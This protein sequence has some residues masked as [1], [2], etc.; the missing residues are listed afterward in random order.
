MAYAFERI[1][2]QAADRILRLDINQQGTIHQTPA[3]LAFLAD[4]QQG[5]LV[6]ATLKDGETPLGS[7]TGLI[8]R[9]FGLRILGSPFPGWSTDYMGFALSAA[10]DRSRAVNA[11]IEFAFQDLGC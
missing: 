4:S 3:W 5:E 8:V 9:K 6:F 2:V 7:F 11:L 10:T 1:D